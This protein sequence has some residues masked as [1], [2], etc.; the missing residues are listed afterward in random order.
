MGLSWEAALTLEYLR[1]GLWVCLPPATQFPVYPDLQPSSWPLPEVSHIRNSWLPEHKA[2]QPSHPSRS[3]SSHLPGQNS[4]LPAS[5]AGTQMWDCPWFCVP[6]E[7]IGEV[8][9]APS[10]TPKAQGPQDKSRAVLLPLLM[11]KLASSL[12]DGLQGSPQ[13][14]GK[15]Q[16][17]SAFIPLASPVSS[18]GAQRGCNTLLCPQQPPGQRKKGS[19][20]KELCISQSPKQRHKLNPCQGSPTGQWILFHR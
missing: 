9:E 10:L 8:R 17:S 4:R 12:C 14:L 5:P 19:G 6:K 18:A 11:A 16:L 3:F 20:N 15:S 7:M 2:P 1:P 13:G